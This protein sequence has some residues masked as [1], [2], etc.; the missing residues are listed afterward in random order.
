MVQSL[1]DRTQESRLRMGAI[2]GATLA[3]ASKVATLAPTSPAARK[4]LS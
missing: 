1:S 4:W 3:S 2:D